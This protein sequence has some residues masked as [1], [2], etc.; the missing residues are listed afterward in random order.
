MEELLNQLNYYSMLIKKLYSCRMLLFL[1]E[2]MYKRK[3]IYFF[4]KQHKS[5]DFKKVMS[6]TALLGTN[7]EKLSNTALRN[8]SQKYKNN[9][10]KY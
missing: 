3:V 8:L 10:R 4:S 7:Q 9:S 2:L 5:T 6:Q 1:K